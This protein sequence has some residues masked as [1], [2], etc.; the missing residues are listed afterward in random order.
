MRATLDPQARELL[1]RLAVAGA[2]RPHQC[3]PEQARA[4]YEAGTPALCGPREPVD[5]VTDHDAGGV[6]A[7]IYR[8]GGDGPLPT[9]V[10]LHGGGW[11]VGSLHSHD[12]LC[13]RLAN[14]TGCAVV[15]VDYRLA[16]EHPFPAAVDDT[17]SAIRWLAEHGGGLGLDPSRLAVGGDSAGGN[18]AAVAARRLRDDLQL[19]LQVLVYPVTDRGFDTESYQRCA[20]G[21]YLLREDMRWYWDRY[22]PDGSGRSHPDAAPLRAA[23][24]AG[25]AAALV[26][27]AGYDP[28][29]DEGVAYAD[30]LRGAGVNVELVEFERQIHGFVRWLAVMDAAGEAVDRIAGALGRA[31]AAARER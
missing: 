5:E 14:R 3:T 1:D 4:N 22:D 19:A 8:P 12:A 11:V 7:R 30:R 29:R 16:P 9:L 20:D 21:Y 23:D 18:L 10:W 2:A 28:L 25:V 17:L 24:L 27:V 13:R 15:A 31:W 26:L 6:P